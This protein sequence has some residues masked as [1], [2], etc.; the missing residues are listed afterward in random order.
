MLVTCRSSTRI[1]WYVLYCESSTC[2]CVYSLFAF[3]RAGLAL[4]RTYAYKHTALC[5]V[6]HCDRASAIA[7]TGVSIYLLPPSSDAMC[8]PSPRP[9]TRR[10]TTRTRTCGMSCCG[11]NR[12]G[13]D[14]PSRRRPCNNNNTQVLR[15]AWRCGPHRPPT[16]I[17]SRPSMER[18]HRHYRT[19]NRVPSVPSSWCRYAT[20]AY[21]YLGGSARTRLYIVG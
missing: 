9:S 15:R 10:R 21:L 7:R 8:S 11:D 5:A 14:R 12:R 13:F 3:K 1:R 18:A 2:L 17:Q 16:R 4:M 20:L 6:E 19:D